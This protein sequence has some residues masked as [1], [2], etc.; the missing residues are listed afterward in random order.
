MESQSNNV[1]TAA[2]EFCDWFASKYSHLR[3][4]QE[5]FSIIAAN[6][7]ATGVPLNAITCQTYISSFALA[8]ET[9]Q[10]SMPKSPTE[11][12]AIER[13]EQL[14]AELLAK[15][16]EKA[17]ED[18]RAE[19]FALQNGRGPGIA[20]AIRGQEQAREASRNADLEARKG[21]ATDRRRQ[22]FAKAKH[23]IEMD[24]VVTNGRLNHARTNEKRKNALI[25]L[26]RAFSDLGK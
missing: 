19:K 3:L 4:T 22:L 17:Y 13:A 11:K 24:Q 23:D 6:L 2:Q 8:V 16:K 10:I 7:K 20:S 9:N 21:I 12:L 18:R 15:E 26:N 25:A 1:T 14:S 5:I